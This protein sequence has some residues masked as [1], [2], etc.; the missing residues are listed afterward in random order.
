MTWPNE[1]EVLDGKTKYATNNKGRTS[2]AD[3]ILPC[4]G[5]RLHVS[6]T[7]ELKPA[8][9][10]PMTGR[11][12]VLPT[13]QQFSESSTPTDTASLASSSTSSI[14]GAQLQTQEDYNHIFAIGDCAQTRAIQAGHT[15]FGQGEVAARNIL[16]LIAKEEGLEKTN[17]EELEEYEAPKPAIKL[18]LGIENGVLVEGESVTPN[19]TGEEDLQALLMGLPIA[20]GMD[21]NE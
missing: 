4:T 6:L 5:Q 14:D 3:I 2:Q 20:M 10:S 11:I 12:R 19:N 1:P 17:D 15:A 21:I 13:Q 8:L 7:A 18:T 9:I 16:R